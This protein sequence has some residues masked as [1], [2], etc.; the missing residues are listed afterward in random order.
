MEENNLLSCPFCDGEARFQRNGKKREYY[1]I[2]KKCGC[3]TPYYRYQFSSTDTLLNEAI[4]TWN[5]R[6][7]IKDIFDRLEIKQ[8]NNC[9]IK[10][11]KM[12]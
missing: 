9:T 10:N 6:K 3:R 11:V 1:V 8:C 4:T 12:T 7:P 2:C 5:T